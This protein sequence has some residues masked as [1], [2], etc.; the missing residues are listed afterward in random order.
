MDFMKWLNSLDEL[1]Y[2]VMSWLL[3]FPITLW[4]ATVRPLRTMADIELQATLPDDRQYAAVLSPPLFLALALLLAHAVS[5]ALGQTDAII[6]NRH[7]LAALV[8]DN[9]TA[10]VLRM[11]V[12]AS[13]PLFLAAR[14]VRGGGGKLDR[15]SLRQPFYEQCYPAAIFAL[16]LSLGTS[17]ALVPDAITR[18]LG[19]ALIVGSIVN[20]CVVE[21]RWFARARSIGHARAFASV[22]VGML[23]GTA[24]MLF[25]GY[26]FTR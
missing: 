1:L 8:D 16:G 2:E 14:L 15:L 22:A 17:L 9:A 10:L 24:L 18:G 5:Q 19:Q 6:A 26:L 13:Y 23:Q 12:F 7:G 3:F 4:R 21:T 11:V 25:I 20:F